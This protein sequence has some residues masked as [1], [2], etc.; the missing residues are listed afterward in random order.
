MSLVK[1]IFLVGLI[2]IASGFECGEVKVKHPIGLSA[3]STPSYAGQWPW[4]VAL[5]RIIPP[6]NSG[7]SK[8]F[9]GATLLNARTLLTGLKEQS[10]TA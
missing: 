5:V 1:I 10:F 3:G 7:K 8:F 6:L 9:C 2:K 4:L